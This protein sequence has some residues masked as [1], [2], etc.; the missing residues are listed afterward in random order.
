ML[1][2]MESSNNYF[3]M[4]DEYAVL[5]LDTLPRVGVHFGMLNVK[6]CSH[7]FSGSLDHISASQ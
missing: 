2:V 7:F 5:Q 1:N 3:Y 4:T 6:E